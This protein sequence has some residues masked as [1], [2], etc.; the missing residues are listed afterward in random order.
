ML[1]RRLPGAGLLQAS[2]QLWTQT[3]GR[4]LQRVED[5]TDF[6]QRRVLVYSFK[7]RKKLCG[8][9]SPRINLAYMWMVIAE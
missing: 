3:A 6:T 4:M 5:L 9:E 2:C 1:E 7:I 8:D